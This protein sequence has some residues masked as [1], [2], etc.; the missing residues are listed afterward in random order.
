MILW[1]SVVT[2][3]TSFSF[4][5]M[6]ALSH[7]FLDES[8]QRFINFLYLFK[9][10]ALSFIDLFYFSF[11]SLYFIHF[12]FN[13]YDFF[14]STN[15]GFCLYFSSSYRCTFGVFLWDFPQVGLYHYKFP[16]ELLLLPPTEYRLLCIH[17][18]F[19]QSS[20]TFKS[21]LISS[22]THWLFSGVL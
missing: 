13:L 6:W 3:V 16:L 8:D 18:H 19:L 14:P 5:I 9:E 15:F 1:I 2:A 11:F 4:F 10:S 20:Y 7:F 17:F 12:Y 22:M 21:S